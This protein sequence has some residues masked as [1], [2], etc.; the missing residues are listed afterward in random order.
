[1]FV[2]V[3][4]ASDFFSASHPHH[5]VQL[6]LYLLASFYVIAVLLFL[7]LARVLRNGHN[8]VGETV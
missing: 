7:A 4:A 8:T 5:S 1:M 3:G 6:A 2:S